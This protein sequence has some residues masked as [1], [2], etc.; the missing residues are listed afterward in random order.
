MEFK[1]FVLAQLA[2]MNI[3]H[4]LHVSPLAEAINETH[5]KKMILLLGH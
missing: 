4:V 5:V 1:Y 3:L 2:L